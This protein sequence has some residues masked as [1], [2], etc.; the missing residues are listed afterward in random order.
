MALTRPP[1]LSAFLATARRA[2]AAPPAQRPVPLAF[3]LGNESADLDSLC[4]TLVLAYLRSH[5]QRK[6]LHIPLSNLPRDDLALR[7]ELSAVLRRAGVRPAELL[8]LSDLPKDQLSPATTRWLL[9]DHNVMTGDLGKQFGASVVGCVDHHVN[10][11]V[12]RAADADEPL[13]IRNC[14]SCASLVVEHSQNSWEALASAGADTAGKDGASVE[15]RG[16]WDAQL[17]FVAL[18]PILIDTTNLTSK[19]KT[20]ETD[21][22]AVEFTEGLIRRAGA[23]YERNEYF[24]EIT[25]LKQDLS[26][27]SYRGVFRKDYKSWSD[28]G[29]KL[30]TSSVA[31][32]FEYLL[33][34]IGEKEAFLA[35]LRKWSEEQELDIVAVLTALQID[36]KFARELLVWAFTAD[37]VKTVKAF[38]DK[39]KSELG[40]ETWQDGKLDDT[41]G[42]KEWRMCWRQNRIEHSRK[43]VAPLLRDSMKS[44]QNNKL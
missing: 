10:E 15:D 4:S 14:G 20:T 11:G 40:L 32:G 27:L 41:S 1:S 5:D 39:N 16:L 35:E 29:F 22:R 34:T 3:V 12:V 7:P 23:E 42:E 2:L 18:A 43:K 30:G 24:E 6:I 37:A 36:G 33:T 19:D 44:F 17:A 25:R 8:T 38:A 28:G 26:Q 13:V 9:V 21:V 31:Q